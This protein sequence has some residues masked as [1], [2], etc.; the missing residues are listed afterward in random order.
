MKQPTGN[1]LPKKI[2]FYSLFFVYFTGGINHFVQP[3]IYIPLIPPYL[4]YV[5][6]LNLLSGLAEVILAI[7]LL[8]SITRKWAMHGIILM[9]FTF[10]PTHIYFIEMG[11]CISE[12]ICLDPWVA[13]VRLIVVHPILIYW[14]FIYR[15]YKT[16]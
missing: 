8:F 10:L 7:G 3:E 6:E 1:S 16:K 15:N 9:L 2:G 13:W 11:S 5:N 14:A 12:S 4:V